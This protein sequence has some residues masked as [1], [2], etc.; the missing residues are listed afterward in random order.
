MIVFN[1]IASFTIIC[2]IKSSVFLKRRKECIS[3]IPCLGTTDMNS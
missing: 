1:A 2:E 3:S